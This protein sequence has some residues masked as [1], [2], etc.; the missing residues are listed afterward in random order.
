VI[1][2]YLK[3]LPV[4]VTFAEDGQEAVKLFGGG[5]YDLVL[6]DLQMPVLDGI[7]A[8]RAIRAL[9]AQRSGPATPIVALSADAGE[10]DKARCAEAGCNDHC[11]K[12]I[13]LERFLALLGKYGKA[14]TKQAVLARDSNS[15][16]VSAGLKK[17]APA[18]LAKRRRDYQKIVGFS[19]AGDFAQIRALAHQLKGSGETYGFPELSSLGAALEAAAEDQDAES[20]ERHTHELHAFLQDHKTV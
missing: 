8:T 14:A 11:A 4:S 1:E 6:M 20:V 13:S 2:I 3:G 16:T 9:E 5:T 17:L 12:P 15:G 10:K 7:G 19:A 18:Y